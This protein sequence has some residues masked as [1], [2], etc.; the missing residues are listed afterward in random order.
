MRKIVLVLGVAIAVASCSGGRHAERM[1]GGEQDSHGC[2]S[3]AGYTWSVVKN[4]CIRVWEDGAE[5]SDKDCPETLASRAVFSADSMRVE[6]FLPYKDK[7]EILSREG[8]EWKGKGL[9]L[10][11]EE[12]GWRLIHK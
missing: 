8:N 2:L 7:N 12:K 3:A 10:V 9:T 6:M 4:D 11:R 1:I 5:V